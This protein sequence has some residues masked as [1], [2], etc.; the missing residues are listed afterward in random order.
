MH[1][2][3]SRPHPSRSLKIAESIRLVQSCNTRSISTSTHDQTF[4]SAGGSQRLSLSDSAPYHTGPY[5]FRQLRLHSPPVL[6][7]DIVLGSRTSPPRHAESSLRALA[8]SSKTSASFAT[9]PSMADSKLTVSS[10]ASPVQ[11][12]RALKGPQR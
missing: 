7:C 12:H 4:C 5:H 6:V 1:G 10:S 9:L 8:R 3:A 2:S 11:S